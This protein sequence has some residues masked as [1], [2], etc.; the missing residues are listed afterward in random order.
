MPPALLSEEVNHVPEEL[1][2]SALVAAH[3]NCVGIFLDGGCDDVGDRAVVSEVNDLGPSCLDQPAHDVDRGVVPIKQRGSSDDAKLVG[4]L[5][6][7]RGHAYAL[8]Q[9]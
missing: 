2:V 3:C 8:N 4:W 9:C 1:I 6:S 7:L 5:V